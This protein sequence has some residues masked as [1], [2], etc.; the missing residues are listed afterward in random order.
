MDVKISFVGERLLREPVD[1]QPKAPVCE[2]HT[3]TGA[4]ER[5]N[6]RLGKQ[7][8]YDASPAGPYGGAHRKLMLASR[9][10][11][12]QQNGDV[13]AANGQQQPYGAKEQIEGF[14]YL[15]RYPIAQ[16][17]DGNPLV[18]LWI[19]IGCLF[20]EFLEIGLQFCRSGFR[21]DSGF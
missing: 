14:A 19:V 18:V 6:D 21:L 7:L 4:N 3:E 17:L 9:A 20:C 1:H 11:R 10:P 5:K 15:V 2:Q 13:A 8:P 16:V 12:E